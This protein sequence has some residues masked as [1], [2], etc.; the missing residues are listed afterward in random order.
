MESPIPRIKEDAR[1]DMLDLLRTSSFDLKK[2]VD[3]EKIDDGLK[4]YVRYILMPHQGK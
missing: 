4:D 2:V 1:S 3:D